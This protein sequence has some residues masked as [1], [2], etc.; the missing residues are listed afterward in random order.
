MPRVC[1]IGMG[2]IGR[3]HARIYRELPHAELVG[4]CDI[5]P[6]RAKAA[7]EEAGVP[8]FLDAQEMLDALKPDICLIT[9]GG[10]E[11]SSDHYIP[12]IQALEAGCHVLGKSLFQTTSNMRS[13]WSRPRGALTAVT[14]SI[15]TIA[16]RRRR[17]G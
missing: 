14:E 5:I 11:Y 4:V 13:R 10:Y 16:L 8:Y 12:T 2:H 9:T 7:G 6:E 3:L 15:S 17:A 1:V